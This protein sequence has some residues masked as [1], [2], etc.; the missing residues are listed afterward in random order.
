MKLAAA[1]VYQGVNSHVKFPLGES[2]G[3]GRVGMGVG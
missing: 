3:L 2:Q 1:L